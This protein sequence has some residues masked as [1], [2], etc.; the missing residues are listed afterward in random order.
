MKKIR[1][2]KLNEVIYNFKIKGL[3]VYV[4]ENL[5]SHNVYAGLNVMYGSS[6]Y[7]YMLDN[8]L[9]TDKHVQLI[10]YLYWSLTY[11]PPNKFLF[12]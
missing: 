2:S 4:W 12:L 10:G 7:R 11:F 9:H 3:D 6:N 1:Y 5:K 8:S